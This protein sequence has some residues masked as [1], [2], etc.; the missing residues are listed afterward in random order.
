MA[1]AFYNE[2]TRTENAESAG[3]SKTTP[4]KYKDGLDTKIVQSMANVGIDLSR[5]RPRTLTKEILIQFKLVILLTDPTLITEDEGKET[6]LI[7]TGNERCLFVVDPFGMTQ[8]NVDTIRDKIHEL[9]ASLI[10]EGKR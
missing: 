3:F 1:A 7:L 6:T 4:E 8:K 5:N 2:L 9:V 10:S